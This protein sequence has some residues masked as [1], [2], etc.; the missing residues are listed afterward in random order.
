[1]GAMKRPI[2]KG[3]IQDRDVVYAEPV[4]FVDM[5]VGCI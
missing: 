1:M 3:A 2:A 5:V 4:M